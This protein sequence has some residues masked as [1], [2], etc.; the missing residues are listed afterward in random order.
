MG[1]DTG[2]RHWWSYT[3]CDHRSLTVYGLSLD[4][5][6]E[7]QNGNLKEVLEKAMME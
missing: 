5:P 2:H 1:G 3:C 6:E 7:Y 4:V